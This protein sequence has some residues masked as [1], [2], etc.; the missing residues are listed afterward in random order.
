MEGMHATQA[1]RRVGVIVRLLGY[2]AWARSFG[3]HGE[4]DDDFSEATTH[5]HQGDLGLEFLSKESRDR[6]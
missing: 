1:L 2:S 4:V 3:R 6:E 5:M